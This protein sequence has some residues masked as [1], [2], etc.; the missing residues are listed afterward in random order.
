MM[1][2]HPLSHGQRRIVLHQI[3]VLGIPESFSYHLG[4]VER[5]KFNWKICEDQSGT[6]IWDPSNGKSFLTMARARKGLQGPRSRSTQRDYSSSAK[7]CYR[8]FAGHGPWNSGRNAMQLQSEFR[9]GGMD[10]SA[11]YKHSRAPEI[12]EVEWRMIIW[13]ENGSC[14]AWG[15]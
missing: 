7:L 2:P 10:S 8:R 3:G 1:S 12:R 13:A 5:V 11:S 14:A 4:F 9:R 6:E 15:S